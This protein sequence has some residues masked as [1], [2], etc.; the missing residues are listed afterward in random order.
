MCLFVG[1]SFKW[2]FFTWT[3]F[4]FHSIE[5]RWLWLLRNLPYSLFYTAL[6][7]FS[8]DALNLKKK[9]QIHLIARDQ[10]IFKLFSGSQDFFRL[11]LFRLL[12]INLAM[13]FKFSTSGWNTSGTQ[14][15]PNAKY[16]YFVF[17]C[18]IIKHQFNWY[19]DFFIFFVDC[20]FILRKKKIEKWIRW[21]E[22]NENKNNS[23][24]EHKQRMSRRI[25]RRKWEIESKDSCSSQNDLL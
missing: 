2:K 15:N 24:A 12:P 14:A 18:T 1:T 5:F 4:D 6:N 13:T 17:I 19:S 11:S 22:E 16:I 9:Q 21:R 3:D 20:A 23:N 8:I 25:R 7:K 10:F